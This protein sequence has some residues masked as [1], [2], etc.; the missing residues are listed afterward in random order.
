MSGLI[1]FQLSVGAR[2]VDL[3]NQ[4][5]RDL[6]YL[7]EVIIVGLK[8]QEVV[9]SAVEELGHHLA[10]CNFTLYAQV[11]EGL[12]SELHLG[13]FLTAF[14][15]RSWTERKDSIDAGLAHLMIAWTDEQA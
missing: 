6:F 3:M 13:Y 14:R 11:L 7:F 1:L 10:Y 9:L 2:Q 4:I 8:I 12:H 15:A 5:E